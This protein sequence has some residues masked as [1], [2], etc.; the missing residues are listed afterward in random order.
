MSAERQFMELLE[1]DAFKPLTSPTKPHLRPHTAANNSVKL[2]AKKFVKSAGAPA[3]KRASVIDP[4]ACFQDPDAADDDFEILE[5]LINDQF[6]NDEFFLTL[7]KHNKDEFN[8]ILNQRKYSD[9]MSSV[10]SNL[11]N[12]NDNLSIP[13]HFKFGNYSTESSEDTDT[14]LQ[15][16]VDV[17]SLQYDLKIE[18]PANKGNATKVSKTKSK[19]NS[20]FGSGDAAQKKVVKT[21]VG[22]DKRGKEL[23]SKVN[24]VELLKYYITCLN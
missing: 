17:Y 21:T 10:D 22:Y 3:P 7:N 19:L 24:K 6:N 2:P 8:V 14:T 18:P 13:E 1:C 5:N 20:S 23:K 15:N 11:I 9:D 16:D 12:E 4:P